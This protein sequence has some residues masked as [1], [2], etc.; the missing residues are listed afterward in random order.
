MYTARAY[1]LLFK[2]K[3][4]RSQV[5]TC[6]YSLACISDLFR[7]SWRPGLNYNPKDADRSVTP[8]EG[9][10]QGNTTSLS[11]QP[12]T[13]ATAFSLLLSSINLQNSCL[14]RTVSRIVAKTDGLPCR[15]PWPDINWSALLQCSLFLPL[16]SR[17]P[18]ATCLRSIFPSQLSSLQVRSDRWW[19]SVNSLLR[20]GPKS[21]TQCLVG[22][23]ACSRL[24]PPRHACHPSSVI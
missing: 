5:L 18:D 6:A 9:S 2:E 11:T 16:G 24:N 3:Y 20:T 7:S 14:N 10:W 8:A 12:Q 22:L 1:A 17:A 23:W 21:F 19:L 4:I 15:R 13:F